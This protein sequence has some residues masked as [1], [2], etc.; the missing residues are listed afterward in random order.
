[1]DVRD[2]DD[3]YVDLFFEKSD[4]IEMHGILT[5]W[6]GDMLA[7][8][9][10]QSDAVDM[11]A[12]VASKLVN[13]DLR[14]MITQDGAELLR[15]ITVDYADRMNLSVEAMSRSMQRF[16]QEKPYQESF[17]M[18]VSRAHAYWAGRMANQLTL[19]L[20]LLNQVTPDQI[21]DTFPE[22]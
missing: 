10:E 21:P 6:L 15:D 9:I 14:C 22:V 11:V 13:G 16:H 7:D 3:G 1:M 19:G 2:R 18:G 20:E 12:D 4:G 5:R 17:L 8:D